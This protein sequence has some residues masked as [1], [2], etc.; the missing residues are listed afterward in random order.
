[1][2]A[3]A[4]RPLTPNHFLYGAASEPLLHLGESSSLA[5]RWSLLQK[6]TQ[7]FLTRFHHEI[8]PHLQLASKTNQNGQD[9][10]VGDVVVFFLPSSDR[11][12]PLAVVEE[13]FPGKDDRVRTLKL[14][15]PQVRG[16]GAAYVRGEDKHFLRDVG[17]VALLLP[18]EKSS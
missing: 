3:P 5:K 18:A 12:W 11:K 4:F 16:A 13:T 9:L 7:A 10:K 2:N 6:I 17:E 14:R 8:R 15:L 1:M